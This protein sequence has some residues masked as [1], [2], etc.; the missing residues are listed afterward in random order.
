M[1]RRVQAQTEDLQ[2]KKQQAELESRRRWDL[3]KELQ[4]AWESGSGI[5]ACVERAEQLVRETHPTE[6]ELP[7]GLSRAIEERRGRHASMI[8]GVSR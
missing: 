4:E 2:V 3:G 5:R 6:P 8:R 7:V 1:L